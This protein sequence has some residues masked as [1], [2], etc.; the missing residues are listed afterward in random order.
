[1][2]NFIAL[3][4][5]LVIGLFILL[6]ALIVKITNNNDKFVDFS[7]SIALGVIVSLII[8][9][10]IPESY[11]MLINKY[12]KNITIIIILG[13]NILGLLLLMLLENWIPHHGHDHGKDLLHLG[14]VSSVAILLHNIIEGMA[15]Y[16]TATQ[17]TSMGMLM[18]LGVSLHNIPLG[19]VV[20]SVVD[21]SN[22]NFYKKIL[23]I[24]SISI[25][26]FIGGLI[27][28]FN[29]NILLNQTLLGIILSITQGMLSYIVI[30]ELLPHIKHCPNKKNSITG[31]LLGIIILVIST[32]FN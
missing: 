15:I 4:F 10:L 7:I 11:G 29:N 24:T 12:N 21:K 19:M 5:T 13:F 25:S 14:I 18:G 23:I 2:N 20:A 27:M 3:I 8:F 31:I 32:F 30:F 1:M 16:A 17:S 9:E 22:T 28:Y 26:T 6:G